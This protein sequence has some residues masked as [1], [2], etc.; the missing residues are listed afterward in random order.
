M[1]ATEMEE[2]MKAAALRAPPGL[3]VFEA[4]RKLMI[5]EGIAHDTNQVGFLQKGGKVHVLQ[6]AESRTIP[7]Q[8]RAQISQEGSRKAWGWI[9][10][11]KEGNETL[12]KW[13]E[14]ED[15]APSP[16]D[17]PAGAP[18]EEEPA[19][20]PTPPPPPPPASSPAAAASA[21][22]RSAPS[23]KHAPPANGNVT[24]PRVTPRGNTTHAPGTSTFH[25]K[26]PAS[27]SSS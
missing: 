22:P 6:R 13:E 7:P 24:T 14:P 5:R 27:N 21:K 16:A 3:E 20:A 10:S 9:D 25:K 15:S 2:E 17:A 12:V 18:A 23:S 4:Q 8:P 11:V 19:D 1:S 26:P